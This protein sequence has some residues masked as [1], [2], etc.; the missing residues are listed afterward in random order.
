MVC[1]VVG[2]IFLDDDF[3]AAGDFFGEACNI[4]GG[5]RAQASVFSCLK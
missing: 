2:A 3:L 5:G 4:R 1:V